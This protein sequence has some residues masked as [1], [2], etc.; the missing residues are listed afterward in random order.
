[1]S[2]YTPIT[3][4]GSIVSYSGKDLYSELD[5]T[6]M[7]NKYKTYD[8]EI[9]SL[10]GQL[11]GDGST[12]ESQLY[13]GIDI[14]QGMWIADSSGDTIMRI[15]SISSKNELGFTCVVE[16]FDM[17][18]IRINNSNTISTQSDVI[19]FSTNQ[20]GEAII[21][22]SS[23]FLP[24]AIDKIQSRLSLNE[25]D[26]RVKFYHNSA[27]SVVEGDI[28]TIDS[29]GNIVL[30]GDVTEATDIK[31]GTVIERL[32]SGKDVYLKPFNDIIQ[33]YKEPESLTG[34][35]GQIYY[36]DPNAPG[37]ITTVQNNNAVYLQ[38]SES[39]PTDILGTNSNLPG[40]GDIFKLNGTTVF[41]GPGGDSVANIAD[42]VNFINGFTAQTNVTSSEF[43]QPGSTSS[44]DNTLAYAGFGLPDDVTVFVQSTGSP[45][46]TPPEITLG[47]GNSSTNIQF[48]SPDGAAFGFDTMSA[49]ATLL[50]IQNEIASAGLDLIATSISI[51][52]GSGQGIKIET[53]GSA[54]GV[55]ITN[56]QNDAAGTTLAGS[57]SVLGLNTNTNVGLPF[58]RLLRDSGGPINITGSPISG[59]FINQGGMV[60]SSNGTVPYLLLIEGV[61]SGTSTVGI[62]TEDDLDQIPNVTSSDG[63]ATGVFISHTPFGDSLVQ[64]SANGLG[65]GVG[66]GVKTLSCYFSVDG[67]TTARAMAD[68]EGGDQLYWNGSVAGYEL[69]SGDLLD[70]VYDKPSV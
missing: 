14:E 48:N 65:V 34:N 33:N 54:T 62:S 8:V 17:L 42:L 60:S 46:T 35:P 7:S 30:A 31:V 19:V 11:T 67:G 20:E 57:G 13:N 61:S 70:V 51:S 3:I 37:E 25:R 9:G 5:E 4:K 21:V 55:Q 58:L 50:A 12:R 41:N 68:I 63:D 52:S 1:M 22:D 18:S 24:G 6:G 45:T 29:S 2:K 36:L 66:D 64:V 27:P 15:V 59:G 39:S 40:A 43:A 56:I 53:T 47:D 26:D 69:D 49:A 44:D 16:D 32:R 10:V 28:V 23:N 38:L